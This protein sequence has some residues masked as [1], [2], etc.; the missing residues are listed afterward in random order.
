MNQ[1]IEKFLDALL[2]SNLL[3]VIEKM[4][5]MHGP[6]QKLRDK[7]FMVHIIKYLFF[8]VL[9]I[10]FSLGTFWL[11]CQYTRLDENL[12][13]FISIVVGI[14]SA[15]IL[16]RIY[17]FES[18]EKNIL[19]EFFKFAMTRVASSL[20]DMISFFI[21]ATCFSWNEIMV[22]IIISIAVVILNY[23]LSKSL[24]FKGK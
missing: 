9:T 18:K 20:F 22:K 7:P 16:N 23:V 14:V 15:Y 12:C 2:A 11:L 13:N 17:V 6:A 8:G 24:V 10:F 19:K 1:L 3:N 5:G 21:L 4:P